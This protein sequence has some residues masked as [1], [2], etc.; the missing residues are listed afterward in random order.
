MDYENSDCE[1]KHNFKT[2]VGCV[3]SMVIWSEFQLI[4]SNNN[5]QKIAIF[6]KNTKSDSQFSQISI[7]QKNFISD[8]FCLCYP[9]SSK[10]KWPS[11]RINFKC[12]SPG[13]R[14]T[15]WKIKNN[16]KNFEYFRHRK[17]D[18]LS[19]NDSLVD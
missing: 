10:S 4:Y 19:R 12:S 18:Y 11:D 15:R 8:I 2:K 1:K 9:I 6:A 16:F 13:W 5:S 17:R 14:W 7:Y 3:F